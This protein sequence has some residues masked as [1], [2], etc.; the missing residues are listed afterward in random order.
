MMK[1]LVGW[2]VGDGLQVSTPVPN[3]TWDWGWALRFLEVG[4]WD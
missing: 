1:N 2:V 3:W 4:F